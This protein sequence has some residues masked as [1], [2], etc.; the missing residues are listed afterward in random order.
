[1]TRD[2][3]IKEYFE[4]G[5]SPTLD[6]NEWLKRPTELS[7]LAVQAKFFKVYII[8]ENSVLGPL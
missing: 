3:V 7:D 4:Q 6:A 1:M 5:V 2:E 8:I